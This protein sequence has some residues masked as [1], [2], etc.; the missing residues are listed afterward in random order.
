MYAW[1]SVGEW[2]SAYIRVH[3]AEASLDESHPDHLAAYEFMVELVGET[4]ELCWSGILEVVARRPSERVLGMVAAGLVEDLLDDSGELF[5]DRIEAQ[6]SADPVFRRM[7]RGVW[8]SGT[9]EVW[10]R[11]VAARAESED[12][13]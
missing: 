10:A 12:A 2:A 5:I 9:P 8:Q 7:L 6:A 4:A 3:E 13:A 1:S 11:L